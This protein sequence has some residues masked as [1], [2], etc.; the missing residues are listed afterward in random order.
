MLYNTPKEQILRN[1]AFHNEQKLQDEIMSF[2]IF[3]Q[4]FTKGD[5]F[6]TPYVLCTFSY[7]CKA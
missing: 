7:V 1:N 3:S 6:R 4:T 2:A 5:F